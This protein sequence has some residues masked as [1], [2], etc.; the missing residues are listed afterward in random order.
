MNAGVIFGVA[1]VVLLCVVRSRFIK[2]MS[3]KDMDLKVKESGGTYGEYSRRLR[4]L[5][6][7]GTFEHFK[8]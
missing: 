6:T 8:L 1:V 3:P 7:K 2:L 5:A 4:K